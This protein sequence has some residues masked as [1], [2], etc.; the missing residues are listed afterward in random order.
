MDFPQSFWKVSR[1]DMNQHARGEDNIEK[2]I[3]IR[4]LKCCRQRE[5]GAFQPGACL[6]QSVV[7]DFD[8][9]KMLKSHFPQR[10]QL[11]SFVAAYLEDARATW[12]VRQETLVEFAPALRRSSFDRERRALPATENSGRCRRARNRSANVPTE[13]SS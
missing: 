10:T 5:L 2:A 12:D 13:L 8:S 6:A 1:R 9:V 4:N 11:V 3:G 7:L